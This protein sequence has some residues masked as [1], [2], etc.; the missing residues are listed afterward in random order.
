M[1]P[2][3]PPATIGERIDALRQKKGLSKRKLADLVDVG[4]STISAWTR[5]GVPRGMTREHLDALARVLDVTVETLYGL[6]PAPAPAP[7][8]P[9]EK[10][11]LDLAHKIGLENARTLLVNCL[12]LGFDRALARLLGADE[13]TLD[14]NRDRSEGPHPRPNNTTGAGRG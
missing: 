13:F 7:L 6:P 9:E 2:H 14:R 12:G 4:A 1:E 11:V 8:T 3:D 10:A 5:K